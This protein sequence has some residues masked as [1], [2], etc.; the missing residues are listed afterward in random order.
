MAWEIEPGWIL[1]VI[2]TL[3]ACVGTLFWQVVAIGKNAMTDRER[4]REENKVLSEKVGN[5]TGQVEV[6]KTIAGPELAKNV[7][8]AVVKAMKA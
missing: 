7:A 8:S 6:L 1:S 3:S 2:G 5:V 4:C